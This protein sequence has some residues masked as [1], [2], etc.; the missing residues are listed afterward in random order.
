MLA[1]ATAP[2]RPSEDVPPPV[3]SAGPD[4]DADAIANHGPNP[5]PASVVRSVA[6]E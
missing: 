5:L 6:S 3:A 2:P 1:P 4:R